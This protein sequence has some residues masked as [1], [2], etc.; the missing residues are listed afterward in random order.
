[1]NQKKYITLALL[2]ASFSILSSCA[3]KPVKTGIPEKTAILPA[4][5]LMDI[6][7]IEDFF[8][9]CERD[10]R[11][12]GEVIVTR[13]L[14]K[15]LT[16]LQ[17][18]DAGGKKYYIL[19]RENITGMIKSVTENTYLDFILINK[20]GAVIYTMRNDNLFGKNVRSALKSTPLGRSYELRGGDIRV[21]DRGMI[22]QGDNAGSLFI[23]IKVS[24]EKSFPGIF[25]LQVGYDKIAALLK[26][27][28]AILTAD[29]RYLIPE[30]E[31]KSMLPYPYLHRLAPP[32]TSGDEATRTFDLPGKGTVSYRYFRF[33]NLTWILISGGS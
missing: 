13:D 9:R 1:M 2:L 5:D 12:A 3:T 30:D 27:N 16:H 7:T 22:D 33:K 28:M 32:G 19:E 25:I 17:G 14:V 20:G 29:G 6:R 10:I 11:K 18:M 21:E 15:N 23:S 24:G 4:D 8:R 31:G 26:K